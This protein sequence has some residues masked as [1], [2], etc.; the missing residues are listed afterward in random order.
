MGED[1][2]VYAEPEAQVYSNSFPVK[3]EQRDG[4]V[5]TNGILPYNLGGGGESSDPYSPDHT[6]SIA[7]AAMDGANNK[8]VP[9]DALETSF[10]NRPTLHH[11]P[12]LSATS[13]NS[14]SFHESSELT[15]YGYAAGE[16]QEFEWAIQ[17]SAFQW[18]SN[19]MSSK[20]IV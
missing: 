10:S 5:A 12:S 6:N 16:P 3:L 14:D 20:M 19:R 8:Y 17:P 4:E 9:R 11:M 1:A 18:P 15:G 2:F 7:R 13:C